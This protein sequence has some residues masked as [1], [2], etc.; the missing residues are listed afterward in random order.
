MVLFNY[1]YKQRMTKNLW[2]CHKVVDEP[3]P[4]LRLVERAAA[5][6][7]WKFHWEKKMKDCADKEYREGFFSATGVKIFTHCISDDYK[8]AEY[9]KNNNLHF[10]WLHPHFYKFLESNNQVIFHENKLN[11]KCIQI[12]TKAILPW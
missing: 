5:L 9:T 4:C 8:S 3:T 12:T 11:G 10:H 6:H 1:S 7:T 2:F